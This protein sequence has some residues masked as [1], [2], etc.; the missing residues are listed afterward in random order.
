MSPT[1]PLI[2]EERPFRSIS[3]FQERPPWYP[4]CVVSILL[5]EFEKYTGMCVNSR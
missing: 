3:T 2:I 1:V 5:I 4:F